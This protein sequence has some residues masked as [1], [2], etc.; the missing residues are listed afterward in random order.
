MPLARICS[1][2]KSVARHK[3]LILD[4]YHPDTLHLRGQGCENPY[5][6]SNPKGVREQTAV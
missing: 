4:T 3:F 6:I 5:L 1:Y 2:V